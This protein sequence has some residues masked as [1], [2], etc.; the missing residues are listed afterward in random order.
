M[1]LGYS[2]AFAL[3]HLTEPLP[4]HVGRAALHAISTKKPI[5]RAATEGAG[6][7]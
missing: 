3:E 4:S 5:D 1:V 7:S 6:L 2:D